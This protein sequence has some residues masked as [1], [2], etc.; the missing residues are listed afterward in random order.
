MEG[1]KQS[2]VTLS[3]AGYNGS[4]VA[5]SPHQAVALLCHFQTF[6]SSHLS[7]PLSPRHVSVSEILKEMLYSF[8][9]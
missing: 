3:L 7:P 2:H 5:P 9:T 4:W 8:L 1:L 6:P